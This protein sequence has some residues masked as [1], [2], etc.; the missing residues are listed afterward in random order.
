VGRWAKGKNGWMGIWVNGWMDGWMDRQTGRQNV[1]GQTP[2][3]APSTGPTEGRGPDCS[4]SHISTALSLHLARHASRGLTS[5]GTALA[6][7]QIP[8]SPNSCPRKAG[9]A[10][11]GD[12]AERGGRRLR[13][14]M[15]HFTLRGF[16]MGLAW[17]NQ[18]NWER[19]TFF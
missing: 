5:L 6:E 19:R 7:R 12:S 15:L 17:R 16:E 2:S 18:G 10:T 9:A 8:R 11:V 1:S 14:K 4:A 3:P 13:G